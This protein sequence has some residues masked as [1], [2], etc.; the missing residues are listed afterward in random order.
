[1]SQCLIIYPMSTGPV[2]ILHAAADEVGDRNGRSANSKRIRH[3]LG[4]AGQYDPRWRVWANL[5]QRCL[6]PRDPS[7][8]NYGGRGITVCERWAGRDG[9][10]N[11]LADMGERPGGTLADGRAFYSIE[12]I[13]NDGPYSPENCRWATPR[14]Q[15]ANQRPHHRDRDLRGRFV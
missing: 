1:M 14:E 9:F 6:N 2:G 3:G 12:R 5:K 15:R 8:H 10:P 7:Y 4:R 13:D 11:F